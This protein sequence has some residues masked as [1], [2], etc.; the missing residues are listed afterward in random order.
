M[1]THKT[2]QHQMSVLI[3]ATINAGC[4][5]E[6]MSQHYEGVSRPVERSFASS[7]TMPYQVRIPTSRLS[8]IM[9]GCQGRAVESLLSP[10][11]QRQVDPEKIH[12]DATLASEASQFCQRPNTQFTLRRCF[13]PTG[14]Q[15][16]GRRQRL[17]I[18]S[19][20]SSAS[21]PGRCHKPSSLNAVTNFPPSLLVD[22]PATNGLDFLTRRDYGRETSRPQGPDLLLDRL[23]QTPLSLV[24]DPCSDES[25]DFQSFVGTGTANRSCHRKLSIFFLAFKRLFDYAGSHP[26]R[27]PGRD[28][29][30]LEPR[31][32]IHV[33]NAGLGRT[34]KRKGQRSLTSFLRKGFVNVKGQRGL[35]QVSLKQLL[36]AKPDWKTLQGLATL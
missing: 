27:R 12:W 1:R 30:D 11:W 18:K 23:E 20:L 4:C 28:T 16:L 25:L 9:Y 36:L 5:I 3:A 17:H 14:Y 7:Y 34:A 32:H 15:E 35:E 6:P 24:R 26:A 29:S 31:S 33:A 19:S 13:S 22:S 2:C 8:S 10:T 21:E